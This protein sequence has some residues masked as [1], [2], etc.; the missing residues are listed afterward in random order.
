MKLG[1][2]RAILVRINNSRDS[3]GCMVGILLLKTSSE[4]RTIN[5]NASSVSNLSNKN[6]DIWKTSFTLQSDFMY[7]I[8]SVWADKIYWAATAKCHSPRGLN[9]RHV[10]SHSSGDRTSKITGLAELVSRETTLPGLHMAAFQVSSHGFDLCRG[11][12]TVLW[13]LSLFSLECQS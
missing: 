12:E 8:L 10:F 5:N 4:L 1:G 3:S 7:D 6:D 11:E 9:N 2:G 13:C